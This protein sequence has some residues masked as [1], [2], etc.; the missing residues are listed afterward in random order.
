MET[1][2]SYSERDYIRMKVGDVLMLCLEDSSAIPIQ[3]L[4]ESLVVIGPESISVLREILNEAGK[5]KSQVADDQAQV[6]QGLMENLNSLGF[7]V[8][9]ANK[10]NYVMRMRPARF[11]DLMKKQGVFDEDTQIQ[12]L[13]LLQDSRDLLIGLNIK[14]DLLSRI[15]EY[16]EDWTWGIFY[17]SSKKG[18]KN[19]PPIQ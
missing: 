13:Q 18:T 2:L 9:I 10:P 1:L 14:L 5:R 11:Y 7:V 17:L 16:L 12:C 3:K 4:V 15:E 8:S 6:L 19:N